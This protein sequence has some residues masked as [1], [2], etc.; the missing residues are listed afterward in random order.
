MSWFRR[1][2]EPEYEV[3]TS[4]VPVSTMVR[5]FIHDIGYGDDVISDFIGLSPISEE[6]ITK[7]EQD[8]IIH[9]L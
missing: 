6:G 5:W 7:E 1:N 3:F 4:E 9:C 2:K 8:R